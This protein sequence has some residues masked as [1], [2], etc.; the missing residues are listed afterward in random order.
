M[1][2]LPIWCIPGLVHH[3]LDVFIA[4]MLSSVLCAPLFGR[5]YCPHAVF[6]ALC[7][8]VLALPEDKLALLDGAPSISAHD[9]NVLKDLI[10]ILTPFEEAT[11]FVQVDSVPSLG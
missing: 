1:F 11:D 6:H 4:C 9:T 2:V 10:D 5:M 7:N 3:Y 8:S